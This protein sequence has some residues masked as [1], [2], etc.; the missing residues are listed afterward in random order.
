VSRIR[1]LIETWEATPLHPGAWL[2]SLFAISLLRNLLEGLLE[3]DHQ[4]TV[5]IALRPGLTDLVHAILAW[6]CI[7]LPA[8]LGLAWIRRIPVAQVSRVTLRVFPLILL[9]PLLDALL[10]QPGHIQ[11]QKDFSELSSSYL[12]LF[13]PGHAVSYVTSGVRVEILLGAAL[14]GSYVAL[15]VERGRAWRAALAVLL[16]YHLPFMEGF[17]PALWAA[18]FR[19]P[20]EVL[21]KRTALG[22]DAP[23]Y[24]LIWYLP[25]FIPAALLWLRASCE[26]AWAALRD[27]L[28]P[29]RLA[30]YLLLLNA[31]FL[32]ATTEGLV[33]WDWLN[34]YDIGELFLLN[35]ALTSAFVSQVA[36]NDFH[37]LEIDRKTNSSRPL[38]SGRVTA[39]TYAWLAGLG[40]GVA[41]AL[42]IVVDEVALYPMLG[43]LSLGWFYSAPPFRFRRFLG[44]S[45]LVLAAIAMGCYLLGA[46]LI[47][48]NLAYRQCNRP[49]VALL[50][51]LIL[52]GS[53]F[54]DLKDLEGDWAQGVHTLAT[55]L[56]V[57]RAYWV[58][59]FLVMAVAAVGLAQGVLPHSPWTWIALGAF[60]MAWLTFRD[61]ERLMRL[62]AVLLGL[63]LLGPVWP[64]S[65]A[66]PS[67]RTSP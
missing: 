61:G 23:E 17:L 16:V 63:L 34:P 13:L 59:G 7:Y 62:L 20:A 48:G 52:A 64:S 8:T 14:A 15:M 56:G 53:Q 19:Q 6:L 9:V 32:A 58:S 31:G 28:R 22:V 60:E 57:R 33:D 39:G 55:W 27:C 49:L 12:S 25:I 26:S 50:G 2:A 35:L 43:I 47:H 24:S 45:H 54:K 40:A 36:L 44:L 18:V 42:S 5:R 41:L 38:A 51:A 66:L 10:A 4:W 1:R 65:P 3:A 46:T 37:D 29:S 21:A 67:T 30:I 11:Y